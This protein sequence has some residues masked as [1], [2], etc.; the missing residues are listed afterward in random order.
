M[1]LLT[2]LG[3]LG[4]LA[5]PLILLLHFLRTRREPLLTSTMRLWEGLQQKPQTTSLR[6]LPLTL[7]LLLQLCLAGA[8][9]L[10][11][12]R[13]A[14]SFLLRQPQHTLFLLDT[15]TSMLAEDAGQPRFN[16]ARQVIQ[17]YLR[18]MD[19]RDTF[20]VIGLNSHPAV[21]LSGD[22]SQKEQT[23]QALDNLSVGGT[24]QDLPAALTLAN[25]LLDFERNNQLIVLTDGNYRV[26]PT[27]LPPLRL[28]ITWQ[29]IPAQLNAPNQALLNVSAATWPD[30]RHRLFARVVNYSDAAVTRNVRVIVDGE[31]YE[32][33]AI[34]LPPQ[35]ESARA[36][37]LAAA[38]QTAAI[39]IIEP[40][41][42]PLDNRA[43]VWLT[44]NQRYRVLLISDAPKAKASDLARAL[45]VQPNVELTVADPTAPAAATDV[46]LTVLEGQPAQQPWP[47]GNVLVVNPPA[48]HPLLPA[49]GPTLDLR[50][51][52]ATSMPLL[53]GIDLSGAY[54]RQVAVRPLPGWAK[55]DLMSVPMTR[56]LGLTPSLVSQT[57][58]QYPA[59]IFHGNMDKTHVMVWAFD[60][61]KSNLSGRPALP[62]LIANTLAALLS[63]LPPAVTPLGEPVALNPNLSVETPGGQR[64]FLPSSAAGGTEGGIFAHTQQPGLYKIYDNQRLLGGFAVQAGSPLESN[65]TARFQPDTLPLPTPAVNIT[66]ETK[67][68]E[69]WP[70][71]AGLALV[72][73]TLEGWLAWRK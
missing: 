11:L 66:P 58:N 53:N 72:V 54:F 24:G 59:L 42:L 43:E 22:A 17:T 32:P 37:T 29:F 6:R 41:A 69:L 51:D 44:G 27:A 16:A 34:D 15:T 38:S 40:D 50:P 13:P 28:P 48:E 35:S 8:L 26:D 62:L 57:V 20:T 25:G 33:V 63:A 46:D 36:W 61:T 56:T 31:A 30:G 45:Q 65:L 10:A 3:L 55:A 4:L 2:P 21:L 68:T 14:L 49:N 23:S 67:Y 64:L 39:E 71:L 12:A 1:S 9:A 60:L 52:A 7:T 19:S 70:W 73:V 5:I 47:A 18:D